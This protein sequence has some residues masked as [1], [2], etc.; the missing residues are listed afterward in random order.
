[1]E[2]SWIA[3]A[4]DVY[5]NPP[6]ARRRD[7]AGD[8]GGHAHPSSAGQSADLKNSQPIAGKKFDNLL[9]R[10]IDQHIQNLGFREPLD[11]Q[12]LSDVV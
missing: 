11:D 10:Q 6:C 5:S 7:V 3:R 4:I 9:V 1:M 8:C 2:A 12:W